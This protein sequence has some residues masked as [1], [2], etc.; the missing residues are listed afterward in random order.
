MKIGN[1]QWGL[2]N[3]ADRVFLWQ[4][5]NA[6]RLVQILKD[7]ISFY[8]ENI[9]QFI[10]NWQKDVFNLPTANTFGLDVWGKILGVKRPTVNPQNYIIDSESTL[11]LYNPN[12]GLWHSIWLSGN[13]PALNVSANGI[14]A[15]YNPISLDDESYRRCLFAK[16]YLM[17]SDA[18]IHSINEYL[19][20]LFPHLNAHV[21]ETGIMEMAIVFR[22][23]VPTDN[24]LTIL[25][26]D[27]FSPRPVGVLMN[28]VVENLS[29][30]TF[31]FQ[32]QSI[33]TLG[34]SAATS[35][36]YQ[37]SMA[38]WGDNTNTQSE[39]DIAKGLGTF[40]NL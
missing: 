14:A 13:M 19:R 1:I 4:Y 12:T 39:E 10:Q 6:L 2:G 28:T 37:N 22:D 34:D 3:A 7:E 30:N 5:D 31:S 24:D 32:E 25:T 8:N 27:D 26:S 15:K 38:T 40:Y 20:L 16:L 23:T 21:K 33:E 18:S 9:T 11:R 35:T 17:Y 29:P 36:A